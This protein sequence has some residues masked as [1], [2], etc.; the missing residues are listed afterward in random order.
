MLQNA[1]DPVTTH[2][3][4]ERLAPPGSRK[5]HL[6]KTFDSFR[7]ELCHTSLAA[8]TIYVHDA[9]RPP[10]RLAQFCLRNLSSGVRIRKCSAFSQ[11]VRIRRT[12][13]SQYG[14]IPPGPAAGWAPSSTSRPRFSRFFLF[15]SRSFFFCVRTGLEVLVSH[16]RHSDPSD[17]ETQNERFR[18]PSRQ[19]FANPAWFIFAEAEGSFP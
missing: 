19:A 13:L 18:Y 8:L 4:G 10:P 7:P 12:F 3:R 16:S 5:E 17:L 14:L 9:P 11:I 2:T 6:T 1:H 15:C